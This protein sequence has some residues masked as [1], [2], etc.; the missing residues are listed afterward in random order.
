NNTASTIQ[1]DAG[2]TYTVSSNIGGGGILNKTGAGTLVLA[3]NNNYGGGTSINGGTISISADN[4]LGNNSA[5]PTIN[6]GTLEIT[7]SFTTNRQFTI[8]DA[9][10]TFQVDA[11]VNWTVNQ[12]ISGSGTLNKTGAGTMI[13]GGNNLGYTGATNILG[14]TLQITKQGH[15]LPNGTSLVVNGGTLDL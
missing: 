2:Q 9:T 14:G 8:G 11:G 1:V 13:L 10:S 12:N 3:S 6:A 7:S 4:N 15:H 5:K